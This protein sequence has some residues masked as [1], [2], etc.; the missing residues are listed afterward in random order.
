MQADLLGAAAL[1]IRDLILI[2]GDPPILGDYPDA[3]AVFDIDAVGLTNL[4]SRL[5]RGL[6][7]GGNDI[8]PSPGFVVGVGLNPTA[9]DLER[10]LARYRWKVE[11]GAE[12][13]VTQPI[14]DV[15]ALDRFLDRLPGRRIPIL[16]GIWPLQSLKNAEFLNTEVPGVK[17][18]DRVLERMA[19]AGDAEAQRRAGLDI[20]LEMVAAVRDR[21]QGIQVSVPFGRVEGVRELLEAVR[22]G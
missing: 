5:N 14:F 2:T 20:A 17:V 15:E 16:A 11:A 7:L 22:A 1:G 4:A 19:A 8:G 13:A 10:E 9:S 21:V 6:D 3:T 18:A 12:Y